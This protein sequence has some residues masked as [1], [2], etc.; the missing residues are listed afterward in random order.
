MLNKGVIDMPYT[1]LL[2]Q[3]I[4][5]SGLTVKEIAE[6][7]TQSGA[8]VTPAYIST[9]KNDKNDRVPSD[10]LSRAIAKAC[11]A[12]ENLL[13]IQAYLDKA[14]KEV[15]E[16]INSLKKF[17]SMGLMGFIENEFT[18]QEQKNIEK[19]ADEMPMAE[20]VSLLAKT[21]EKLDIKKLPGPMS[22]KVTNQ[23]DELIIKQT[24]S[25]AAGIAV[26]DN[27]MA[28]IINK[29]N[30]VTVEIKA[31]KEYKTGDILCFTEKEAP[32]KIL[33]RKAVFNGE[34]RK[35]ITLLPVNAEFTPKTVNTDSLI[36]LGKVK[37]IIVDL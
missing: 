34:G 17:F 9:L 16:A 7:C 18:T 37:Q 22:Y 26:S 10:E 36:I 23:S 19:I 29:G 13:V 35:S 20:F 12:D 6:R 8:K 28:P 24:L 25:Q 4:S 14:P 33:V 31:L 32:K 2:N 3:M 30:K 11:G 21:N 27:G 5:K 15:S 1:Q